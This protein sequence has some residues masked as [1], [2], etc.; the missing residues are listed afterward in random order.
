MKRTQTLLL[1]IAVSVY[2]TS[3]WAQHGHPGGMGGGNGSASG[4]GHGASVH[5]TSLSTAHGMTM[6]QI[7]TKNTALSGKIQKLTGIDAQQA[8][9]GFK[10][11]GQCVA[12]AHVSKN[13]GLNFACLKADMTGT[14]APQGTSC[15]AGSTSNSKSMSLGQA[16]HTLRPTANSRTESQKATKQANKDIDDTNS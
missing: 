12:A 2:C 9:S 6:N 5:N 11:L 1:A 7:L 16:I 8:C 4:V 14:A 3:A 15:P 13:L 10:N